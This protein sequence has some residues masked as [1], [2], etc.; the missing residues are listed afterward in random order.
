MSPEEQPGFL[1]PPVLLDDYADMGDVLAKALRGEISLK[2]AE[3]VWHRCLA[4]W[5]ISLLPGHDRCEHGY[6]AGCGE[7]C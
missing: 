5:L 2:A 7:C 4:C 1:V 3:P 6:T